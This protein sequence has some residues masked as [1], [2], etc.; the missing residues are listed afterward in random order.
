MINITNLDKIYLNFLMSDL[1][2]LY[3]E[4]NAERFIFKMYVNF[5]NTLCLYNKIIIHKYCLR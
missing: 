4:K 3:D 2:Q 1:Y 5:T